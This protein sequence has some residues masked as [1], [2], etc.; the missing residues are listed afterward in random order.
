MTLRVDV[1]PPL[2]L[3]V[4][5]R[6][7]WKPLVFPLAEPN[8]RLY[9]KARHGLYHGLR[10]LGLGDGDEILAPAYHHG[11]EIEVLERAGITLRFYDAT[12]DLAPDDAELD[13]L[14]SERTRALYLIHYL[15]IPQDVARWR[16]WCDER[17]L[18]LIEDAAQ[19]WLATVG[20]RPAGSFGD[21]AIFCLYKT[22]GV[23]D[24]AAVVSTPPIA[25]NNVLQAQAG[26]L[27]LAKR[28]AW[29]AMGR[30]ARVAGALSRADRG[31]DYDVRKDFET[32]DPHTPPSR[33]T[34]LALPRIVTAT[35]ADKRRANYRALLDAAEVPPPFDALSPGASPFGLPVSTHDKPRLLAR[36]AEHGVG[37]LDFW[38]IPHPALPQDEFPGAALRRAGT[39]VVPVHQEL[40]EEDVARVAAAL[41]T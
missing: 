31:A 25:S 40:R 35:A 9:A 28:H 24:G 19:S 39:V 7:A 1:W 37:A 36:L 18:L 3:D 16:R 30:S 8:V 27:E 26:V 15:G 33:A 23:P 6:R 34:R 22:F 20:G 38:S 32:G 5:A 14:L 17:G 4:W 2:P 21:L 10:A 29:W 12:R 11:S 41:R 13:R